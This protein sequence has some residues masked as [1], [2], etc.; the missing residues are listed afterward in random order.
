MSK[1]RANSHQRRVH[2]A[3]GYGVMC[4]PVNNP[5]VRVAGLPRSTIAGEVTCQH[6]RRMA[7][8]GPLWA[9]DMREAI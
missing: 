3:T 4:Q 1:S 9:D 5:R 8:L 6:C 2:L 7:S